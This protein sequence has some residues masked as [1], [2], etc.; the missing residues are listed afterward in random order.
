MFVGTMRFPIG[1]SRYEVCDG[2][3]DARGALAME[4]GV[5]LRLRDRRP[6]RALLLPFFIAGGILIALR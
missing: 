5:V 1:I 4:L 3:A 6:S 2:V